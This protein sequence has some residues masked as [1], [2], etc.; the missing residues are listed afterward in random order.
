MKIPYTYSV[1]RYVHDP[2]SEEFANVGIVLYAP[3]TRFL[4]VRCDTRYS[5]ASAFFGRIEGAHFRELIRHIEAHIS[6]LSDD[7]HSKLRFDHPK[8]VRGW[9]DTIL[10]PDDSSFQ[11][12]DVR[13]GISSDPELT[14]EELYER[15]VLRRLAAPE[16]TSRTDDQVLRVFKEPMVER[17]IY[18][19]LH[20]KTITV[21]DYQ[22]RFPL[23]WKNGRWNTSEAVSF[24]LHDTESILAKAHKWLG[25]MVNLQESEEAFKLYLLLGSPR[26]E[27]LGTSYHK[28]KN[29]LHKAEIDHEF[30][31]EHDA[32]S[33]A[34]RVE[35]ELFE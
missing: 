21:A 14:L 29:I 32:A 2:V 8:D 33:F 20:P 34:D 6:R 3:E 4:G 26:I 24:D 27:G 10:P 17:G 15:F 19:R 11:F 18:S 25:R 28:A 9:V 23:A 12:S 5:R 22:H 35:G 31:E 30:V 1:L 13:G 7:L 16:K